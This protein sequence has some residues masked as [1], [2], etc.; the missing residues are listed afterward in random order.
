MK[1]RKWSLHVGDAEDLAVE[2]VAGLKGGDAHSGL[3]PEAGS[4]LEE[5]LALGGLVEVPECRALYL[6]EG[7]SMFVADKGRME[8]LRKELSRSISKEG[9]GEM[10]VE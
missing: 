3:V 1:A 2:L 4:K 6:S 8:G 7:V 10:E 5:E 9:L